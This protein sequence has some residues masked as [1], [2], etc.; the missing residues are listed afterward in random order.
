MANLLFK[1]NGFKEWD[2]VSR[3]VVIGGS[4]YSLQPKL[5]IL[6]SHQSMQHSAATCPPRSFLFPSLNYPW[7]F[8]AQNIHSSE[9]EISLGFLEQMGI[10]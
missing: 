1:S 7:L 6:L 9:R 2:K 8:P 10:E 3:G 5:I 4:D